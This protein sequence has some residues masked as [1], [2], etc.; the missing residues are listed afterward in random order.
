MKVLP[1]EEEPTNQQR[2][3][4]EKEVEVMVVVAGVLKRLCHLSA[5]RFYHHQRSRR[6]MTV[7]KWEIAGAT[8]NECS[9]ATLSASCLLCSTIGHHG[10][11]LHYVL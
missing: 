9:A 4:E 2:E 11:G 8:G 7:G 3:V 6:K 5:R 1:E 10:M